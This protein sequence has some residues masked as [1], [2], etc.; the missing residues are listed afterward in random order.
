MV[1][2][3]PKLINENQKETSTTPEK[4]SNNDAKLQYHIVVFGE[5]LYHLSVINNTTVDKLMELNNL[6][7]DKI[8]VGQRLRVN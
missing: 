1:N 3:T 2:E 6:K 4:V 5:T 8:I 7:S